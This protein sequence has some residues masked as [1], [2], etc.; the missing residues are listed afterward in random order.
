MSITATVQPEII[1]ML[2]TELTSAGVSTVVLDGLPVGS[3]M[4]RA[5]AVQPR[6]SEVLVMRGLLAPKRASKPNRVHPQ[7]HFAGLPVGYSV[8][9][10]CGPMLH[11]EQHHI[12]AYLEKAL[13]KAGVPVL[14][15][16]TKWLRCTRTRT[17][18]APTS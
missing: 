12:E 3:K 4:P 1:E 16:I 9:Q 14:R 7:G 11:L 15:A 17:A 8:L 18:C 2:A 5:A 10:P 13:T 6:T